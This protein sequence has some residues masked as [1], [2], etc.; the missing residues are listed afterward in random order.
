MDGEGK[1]CNATCSDF[2]DADISNDVQ[3]IQ[4]IFN[5]HQRS[6]GNGFH[7]FA[8]FEHHCKFETPEALGDCFP[9]EPNSISTSTK[10]PKVAIKSGK[11]YE[12]CELAKELRYKYNFPL[13]QIPTWICIVQRESNFDTSAVGRLNADGSL[14][15]GLFQASTKMLR[16]I[17]HSHGLFFLFFS[18]FL[19]KFYTQAFNF[20]AFA[21]DSFFSVSYLS[22]L[23]IFFHFHHSFKTI[24]TVLRLDFLNFFSD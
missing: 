23:L 18:S 11:I 5:E 16:K 2:L 1:E 15:N 10:P 6:N 8:P 12:R 19:H 17:F 9:T 20:F 22:Y 21:A 14:D 13:E 4:R 24:F 3:C 7:A